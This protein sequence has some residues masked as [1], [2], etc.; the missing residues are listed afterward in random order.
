MYCAPPKR[1]TKELV[2]LEQNIKLLRCKQ[3]LNAYP[4]F[5]PSLLALSPQE[6]ITCF[7]PS[8]ST[9]PVDNLLNGNIDYVP[10]NL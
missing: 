1:N 9:L 8:V 6:N 10:S 7:L 4:S 2:I 3:F 5:N